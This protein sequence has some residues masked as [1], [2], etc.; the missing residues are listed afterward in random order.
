ML[1][2]VKDKPKVLDVDFNSQGFLSTHPQGVR[3]LRKKQY[4]ISDD[5]SIHVPKG[6]RQRFLHKITK[7]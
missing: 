5:I 7:K 2:A 1:L 4:R 6:V 3:L